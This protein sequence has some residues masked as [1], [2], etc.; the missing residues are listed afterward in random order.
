[1]QHVHEDKN[2]FISNFFFLRFEMKVKILKLN[3]YYCIKNLL[4]SWIQWNLE[5][6][7]WI[8]I[9]TTEICTMLLNAWPNMVDRQTHCIKYEGSIT[10]NYDM[11]QPDKTRL[12]DVFSKCFRPVQSRP[13]GK[14]FSHTSMHWTLKQKLKNAYLFSALEI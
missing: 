12:E 13:F 9:Y 10:Y 8:C 6:S 5:Q 2:Y 11:L 7:F 14:L 4:F 3:V 1:M